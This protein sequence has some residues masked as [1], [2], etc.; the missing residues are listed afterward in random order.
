LSV[1]GVAGAVIALF[2]I[3]LVFRHSLETAS[4]VAML[5]ALAAAVCMALATVAVKKF[6]EVDPVVENAVGMAVG[7]GALLVLSLVLGEVR[8]L[9]NATATWL[10][11]AYLTLIGSIAVFLLYLFV[12]RRMTA[13]GTAYILLL[14]PLAAVPLGAWLLDEPLHQSFLIGGAFVLA[15]VYIGLIARPNR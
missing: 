4:A 11:L 6:P 1:R 14:A 8:S 15:G 12:L 9:P 2:G 3:G 5:A 10:S 7:G 13:S